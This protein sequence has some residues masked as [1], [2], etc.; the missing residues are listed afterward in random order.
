[1]KSGNKEEKAVQ[2]LAIDSTLSPDYIIVNGVDSR[3]LSSIWVDT[4]P[5]PP[6]AKQRYTKENAG[7]D[8][9]NFT[10]DD[11]Y[12]NITLKVTAYSF[13]DDFDNTAFY[14]YFKNAT[15]LI[16][17]RFSNYCY[18][19][20]YVEIAEP[21]SVSNG[22]RIKYTIAF[23]CEPFKYSAENEFVALPEWVGYTTQNH[24]TRYSKPVFVIDTSSATDL[25]LTVNGESLAIANAPAFTQIMI[26]CESMTASS[27]IV[28]N[29]YSTGKFPFFA[30]GDNMISVSSNSGTISSVAIKKNE[31]WY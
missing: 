22:A 4:P 11:E 21:E 30:V 16:T 18:H 3:T 28:L 29:P 6:F 9:D 19:V 13:P 7:S 27:D 10:L 14:A 20:K 17:S 23:E 12:E 8:T 15:T 31:R 1:M 5:V 24:G 26:D 2:D 25:T